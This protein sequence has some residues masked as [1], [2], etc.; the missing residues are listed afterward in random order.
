MDEGLPSDAVGNRVSCDGERGTVRFVGTVPPTAG[1]WLGVEWDNPERGKHDGTHE[2]VHYFTCRHPKG[3]SF[4]RP[5]KASFGVDYLTAIRGR[6]KKV[7]QILKEEITISSKTVEMVGFEAV[8]EKQKE[9]FLTTVALRM[10]EVSKPGVENEIRKITPHV[11][12]LDLSANLLSQW[13]DVAAITEQMEPLRELVLSHN[14]LCVPTKPVALNQAFSCLKVLSLKKCTLT[15]PQL[16]ECAPMW[17]QLEELYVSENDITKLESPSQ[18][19]LESLTI[20]DLSDNPLVEDSLLSISQ[21]PRL[22]N[23]NLS[24]TGLST[25]W[26]NDAQPGFKTAMF[27]ALKMLA[28]NNNNISDWLVVSELEKLSSLVKLS[29]RNNPFLSRENNPE[30]ATQLLIARVGKLEVLNRSQI[31]LEERRGAELDYCKMFGLEWLASGGHRD[32]Q[33]NHPST[34]FTTQH[35]RYLMLIQKYG[36]PE[37]G[38]LKKPEPFALKNQLLSI[39]FLCPEDSDRKPI[40][41]KLPD[42][43]IIQKVKG[44]LY[45]LLKIPGVQL[46]LSYASSKIYSLFTDNTCSEQ[47]VHRCSQCVSVKLTPQME[48]TEIDID[49]DLKPLQ[50]YSIED[51]DKVL[52]RWS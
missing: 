44:L 3:G 46:K 10:C 34:E 1:L 25:I 30:T 19:V 28:L 2:G 11:V 47:V 37:E 52:V 17:P 8:S 26:F 12:S 4:V 5:K 9:E 6:Y 22:E 38:E 49:N 42:S 14:R 20:L 16:L 43:M 27:P 31:T 48:G 40:V 51:G 29:C 13:E 50:F 35:P 7:Q 45:R 21:L 36:A 32:P 15:W 24:K 18:Q 39:T 33:Q 41:K 23:L